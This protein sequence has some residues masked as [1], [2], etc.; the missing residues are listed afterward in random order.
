[1]KHKDDCNMAFGRKDP[2]C[3]RCMELI[4][5]SPARSGWQKNYY[6]QKAREKSYSRFYEKEFIRHQALNHRGVNPGGYCLDCEYGR[7]FS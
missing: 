2:S 7:D 4:N 3:P 6:T 5:G 1:M